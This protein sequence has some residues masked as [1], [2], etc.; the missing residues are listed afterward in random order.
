[1]SQSLARNW[2][3]LVYNTKDRRPMIATAIQPRLYAYQAG[4][5]EKQSSPARRIGGIDDHVHALF[6]LSKNY[7][8]KDI[9]EEVKTASSKWI[10]TSDGTGDSSFYWQGGYGA[11]SVS[12]SQVDSVV[13]Y[14][15]NQ[16]EHHRT[17][18]FQ[19]ELKKLFKLH[20]IE[21]DERYVWE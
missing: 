9:V 17:M 2:I 1:M 7:A 21:F 3:H 10:K 4:I 14:I 19:E 18:T 20:Q 16:A 6:L 12:E 15:E 8:L 11:F 13:M 5:F